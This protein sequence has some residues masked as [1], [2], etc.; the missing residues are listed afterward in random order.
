MATSRLVY[1]GAVEHDG[2]VV[3]PAE[4]WA[5]GTTCVLFAPGPDGRLAPVTTLHDVVLSLDDD[6]HL[7]IAGSDG[8]LRAAARAE[9]LGSW[10]GMTVEWPDEPKWTATTITWSTA[11]VEVSASNRQPR[12]LPGATTHVVGRERWISTFG[13]D[14]RIMVGPAGAGC[15]CRGGS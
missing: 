6:R 15:G 11:G 13:S 1:R 5:I 12:S 14:E 3:A 9:T 7:V 10:V 2:G 4:V 8:E